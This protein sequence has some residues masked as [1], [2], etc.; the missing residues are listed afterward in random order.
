M[1]F[2][3]LFAFRYA[4]PRRLDRVI[5]QWLDFNNLEYIGHA[6]RLCRLGGRG[7]ILR[8]VWHCMQPRD[9]P[10]FDAVASARITQETLVNAATEQAMFARAVPPLE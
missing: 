1:Y 7:E 8:L 3:C 4:S 9:Y 5:N 10:G 2:Q 6:R